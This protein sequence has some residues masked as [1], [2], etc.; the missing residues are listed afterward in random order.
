MSADPEEEDVL[1]S[2][3]DSVLDATPLR[4]SIE[5]LV[6]M[7]LDADIAEIQKPI[8]PAPF[9]TESIEQLFTTSTIFQNKGIIFNQIQEKIWQL[10]YKG[11]NYNVTFSPE[12]FDEMPSLRLMTFGDALFE[13]LMYFCKA[14]SA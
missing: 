10:S 12:L 4:L 2:D 11:C 9:T 3:F 5:E 1:M 8:Y 14:Y 6:A 13:E 7:D